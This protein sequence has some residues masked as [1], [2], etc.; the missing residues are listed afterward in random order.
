MLGWLEKEAVV[1]E[2]EYKGVYEDECYDSTLY[3]F[4]SFT[5]PPTCPITCM[6]HVTCPK[7]AKASKA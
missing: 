4:F 2:D 5:C 6:P 3:S 7:A 1:V